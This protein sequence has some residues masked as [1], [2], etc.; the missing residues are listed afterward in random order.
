MEC[1]LD[2]NLDSSETSMN[3]SQIEFKDIDDF[4]EKFAK[5]FNSEQAREESKRRIREWWGK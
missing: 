1:Q 4:E 2:N 3:T 5:G